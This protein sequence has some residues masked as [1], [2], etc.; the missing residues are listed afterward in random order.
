MLALALAVGVATQAQAAPRAFYGV[1]P[2]TPLEGRE[3]QRMGAGGVGTLR[4]MLNWASAN[5]TRAKG[6]YRWG[7]FDPVVAE[8][9]Q[10]KITVLPFIFGT[11]K[12]VA[13]GLDG[14]NCGS[15]CELY[16]PRRKAARE[17]WRAFLGEAVERYGRGGEFWAE[18][19][20]LPK[21]PIR[22]WQI[23]NEQNS[24]S[25]YAPRPTVKGYAKLL[26][27]AAAA[28]NARD[29]RSDVVLGGMAELAG[30]RAAVPGSNYLR[31]LYRRRGVKRDF[32]GVAPHPYGA[33]LKGV[34]QQVAGFRREIKRAGDHGVGLWVTEIGW[35]S[36]RG[37]N[38]LSVGKR[39][40]ARRLGQAYRYFQR[41]R[42]R[43]NMKN[44]TWFSWRDSRT[45]ICEWCASS[46]LYSKGAK[47]KPAWRAYQRVAR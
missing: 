40:Q 11:P 33:Q 42:R 35:G 13:K 17:A 44:V 26:D 32:D 3:F 36:A 38:P 14:R 1:S 15:S 47:P 23:W 46:G 43:M 12:W 22:A 9:A 28:I 25:F 10:H 39:G 30:V 6:D 5:P 4:S 31:K 37:S 20:S 7:G 18:N 34:R 8:A 41:N 27:A 24:K 29:R 2:Q 19:P 16:A 21:R 45:S